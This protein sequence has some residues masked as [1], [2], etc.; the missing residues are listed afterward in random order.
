MPKETYNAENITVLEGLEAVR[1]RPGMYIGS[2]STKGLNHLIYEIVDNAV[3]E[4]LAGYCSEIHVYLEKDGSVTVEDNGRGIPVDYHEKEKKS[5]L[6]VAMTVLHAGGKFDKGSYKVS[7]GLHG[8]GASVVNALSEWV[9]VENSRDGYV[10]TIR[11]ERGKVARPFRCEGETDRHGLY[12]RFKPDATLFEETVFDY[13]TILTR[14]R[15]QSFLNAGVRIILT[16]ERPGKEQSEVLHYE[17]GLV[18]F[19]EYL[20]RIRSVTPL[21][22]TPIYM[23]GE[24]NGSVAEVAMQYNDSYNESILSFANNINTTEGGT[25]ETGFKAALTKVF[26]DYARKVADYLNRYDV[27]AQVDDRNEKIGRKIRDNELKRLPYLLIVGEKEQENGEVSV[28][29]QGEGD[30]GSM[31]IATFAAKINQEVAEMTQQ[32]NA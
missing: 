32:P 31:K 30:Q 28:R 1:V 26:N 8:V 13:D 5:A 24:K 4:H 2:V 7:G 14:M 29:K 12:V 6:E 10:Y 27:R 23:K 3:D 20:T 21:H 11:F 9:E 16:D 15:E 25:H 17:G 18:S 19:V 22:P